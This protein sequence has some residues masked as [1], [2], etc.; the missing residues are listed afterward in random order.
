[1]RGRQGSTTTPA[2]PS[3]CPE[4]GQVRAPSLCAPES[5]RSPNRQSLVGRSCRMSELSQCRE[6]RNGLAALAA[7][8]QTLSTLEHPSEPN[9]GTAG[10]APVKEAAPVWGPAPSPGG[11]GP[12]RLPYVENR[13][14]L[15]DFFQRLVQA[16]RPARRFFRLGD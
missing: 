12:A 10:P 3:A 13:D 5:G 1:P 2:S 16:V 7:G 11:P 15:D 6:D 9:P 14:G 8:S 4:R